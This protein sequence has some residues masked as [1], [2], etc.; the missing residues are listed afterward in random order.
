M[1]S[2]VVLAGPQGPTVTSPRAVLLWPRDFLWSAGLKQFIESCRK[3][4]LL[5]G[6]E[7]S[8]VLESLLGLVA[9]KMGLRIAGFQRWKRVMAGRTSKEIEGASARGHLESVAKIVN[10]ERAAARHLPFST[11]CLEQSLVLLWLLRKRGI[12]A[13]LRIGARKEADRFEAHAWVEYQGAALNDAGNEHLH[14]V[15]F[16]GPISSLETQTH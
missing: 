13:G 7:R 5:S 14:F 15:P 6:F 12:P 9:T 2:P 3:F 4:P 16:E 8:I 10:L 11:N 1:L